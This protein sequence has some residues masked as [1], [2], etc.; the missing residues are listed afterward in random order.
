MW[1]AI[2]CRAVAYMLSL[3][4]Q[5]LRM[6]VITILCLCCACL[7]TIFSVF[8]SLKSNS[9]P[10]PITFLFPA[11]DQLYPVEAWAIVT[12]SANYLAVSR[13]CHVLRI[14]QYKARDERCHEHL[15]VQVELS[16]PHEQ[17][18]GGWIL[19]DCNP[20]SNNDG[21]KPPSTV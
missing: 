5:S 9:R 16:S 3:A 15:Q 12:L 17:P 1:H 20:P 4:C 21:S 2:V 19:V 10:E 11:C 18:R 7:Y 14:V 8:Q 6:A 13:T